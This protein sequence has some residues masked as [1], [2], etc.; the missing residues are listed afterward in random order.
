MTKRLLILFIALIHYSG[1]FSQQFPSDLWHEGKLVLAN[2]EV[3]EGSLKYDLDRGIVQVEMGEKFLTFGANSIFYFKIFDVT[4][5]ANREF[6]VLPYGLVTN[7]KAPVIFEVL[8]EGNISLLC[9]ER[10][11]SKN[12]TAANPYYYSTPTYQQDV[13]VYDYYF[14]DRQ[15]NITPYNLKKKE[16]LQVVVK[17]QSQVSEFIKKNRLKFDRRNDIVRIIAFYNALI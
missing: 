5:E 6:Y 10:I 8:V 7:Y 3:Y 1:S 9:R 14:L 4:V 2:E 17:R 11:T 15:G 12:V 13:L 16:L